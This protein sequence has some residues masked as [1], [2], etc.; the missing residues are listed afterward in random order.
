MRPGASSAWRGPNGARG[1]SAGPRDAGVPLA[2]LALA[3]LDRLRVV[4]VVRVALA[5][6]LDAQFGQLLKP[7]LAGDLLHLL[8][9]ASHRAL[10]LAARPFVQ[11]V[12]GAAITEEQRAR[13][14][15]VV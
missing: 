6:G 9:G 15:R 1:R 3:L 5:V 8:E 14:L 12:A 11:P 13:A 7:A 2:V 10:P 4:E